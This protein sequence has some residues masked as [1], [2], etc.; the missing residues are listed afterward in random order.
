M[1]LEITYI[2]DNED[3]SDEEYE[4]KSER[5]VILETC[6]IVNA[7]ERLIVLNP[8]ESVEDIYKTKEVNK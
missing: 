1:R 3:W 4:E 2:V 5:T 7:I 8:G 6:D